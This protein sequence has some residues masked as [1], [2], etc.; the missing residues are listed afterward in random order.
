M[1]ETL[2]LTL[3]Q[4]SDRSFLGPS[5]PLPSA[6]GW[7]LI[8]PPRWALQQ[9]VHSPLETGGSLDMLSRHEVHLIA[10]LLPRDHRRAERGYRPDGQRPQAGSASAFGW[11]CGLRRVVRQIWLSRPALSVATIPLSVPNCVATRGFTLVREAP[12]QRDTSE[13][14]R[15]NRSHS[16]GPAKIAV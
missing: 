6:A 10:H 15:P 3:W 16:I 5:S 12:R 14:H 13:S 11:N 7:L 8:K 1:S 4:P 2:G 9:R